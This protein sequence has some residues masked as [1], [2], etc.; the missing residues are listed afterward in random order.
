MPS[1]TNVR[2]DA[3]TI[4]RIADF[5]DG[6][7]AELF[8]NDDARGSVMVGVKDLSRLDEADQRML[9]VVDS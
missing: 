3:A 4:T 5:P 9:Y 6:L 1:G 7:P 2:I 8:L